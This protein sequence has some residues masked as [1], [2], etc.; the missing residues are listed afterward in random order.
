M[1]GDMHE[2]K[3]ILRDHGHRLSRME[4]SITPLRREQASDAENVA[5]LE[6]RIDQ[7]TDEVNRIKRRLDVLD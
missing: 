7:L 3:E 2:V 1:R 4:I 5:D 6:A